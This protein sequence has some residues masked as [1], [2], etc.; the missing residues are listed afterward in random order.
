MVAEL[1]ERGNRVRYGLS[2][3]KAKQTHIRR[4]GMVSYCGKLLVGMLRTKPVT[5]TLCPRC[6]SYKSKADNP[7]PKPVPKVRP[8]KK[9]PVKQP[10]YF[11][12]LPEDHPDLPGM[13][14]Y[15]SSNK[16]DVDAVAQ[17]NKGSEVWEVGYHHEEEQSA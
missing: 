16:P 11:V 10:W 6:S 15:R 5:D 13:I 9:P 14:I 7:K 4:A 12:Q 3:A 2:G 8:K 1:V 17:R